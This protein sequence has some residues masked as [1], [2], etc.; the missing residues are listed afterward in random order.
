MQIIH[1]LTCQ[2]MTFIRTYYSTF[3]S[4]LSNK[5]N[6]DRIEIRQPLLLIQPT[7]A[8]YYQSHM[9]F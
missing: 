3:K 8:N 4:I 9:C 1:S 7:L 5:V 2:Q 6:N